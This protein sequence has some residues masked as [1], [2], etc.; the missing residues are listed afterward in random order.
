MMTKNEFKAAAIKKWMELNA[1]I[2]VRLD[3]N[4]EE[5][6]AWFEE[7]FPR[8]E[9]EK[10]VEP[11]PRWRNTISGSTYRVRKVN[12]AW[13]V[14][15]GFPSGI[16]SKQ[17]MVSGLDDDFSS[18]RK[19]TDALDDYYKHESNWE[20]CDEVEAPQDSYDEVLAE[21]K[22][23]RVKLGLGHIFGTGDGQWG[24]MKCDL[25]GAEIFAN[26]TLPELRGTLRERAKPKPVTKDAVTAA[27]ERIRLDCGDSACDEDLDILEQFAKEL[28]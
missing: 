2:S 8:E 21:I 4:A 7:N 15:Y 5:F 20:R 25:S 28:P 18:E 11:K 12:Q 26:Y 6:I 9:T 1:R 24:I 3:Q 22:T 27:V 17:A 23:L 19:A 10:E 16:G 13:E 14:W